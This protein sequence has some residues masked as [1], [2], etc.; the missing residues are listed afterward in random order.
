M[1]CEKT[2]NGTSIQAKKCYTKATLY[3]QQKIKILIAIGDK[4]KKLSIKIN[5]N[6]LQNTSYIWH[7]NLVIYNV[8][9]DNFMIGN[10]SN[11][12][13]RQKWDYLS[14]EEKK[15]NKKIY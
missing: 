14:P 5:A 13:N 4:I 2:E 11:K 3:L 6:E 12:N 9:L 1:T 15:Q 8:K 7:I 10:K